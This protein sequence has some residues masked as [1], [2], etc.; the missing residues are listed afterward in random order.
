MAG[1]DTRAMSEPAY[2]HLTV[3]QVDP[4]LTRPPSSHLFHSGSG[5]SKL[6]QTTIKS[7]LALLTPGLLTIQTIVV[8]CSPAQAVRLPRLPTFARK[9]SILCLTP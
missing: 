6:D 1:N 9:A 5:G 8:H 4:S 7:P 2:R 3:A